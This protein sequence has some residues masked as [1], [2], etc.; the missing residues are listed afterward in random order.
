MTAQPQRGEHL[1][2][3]SGMC[4]ESLKPKAIRSA[5]GGETRSTKSEILNKFKL[6]KF[7]AQDVSVTLAIGL[8]LRKTFQSVVSSQSK[9]SRDTEWR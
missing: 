4:F 3:L 8:A 6:P 2:P 7:R 1:L 9:G 5:V